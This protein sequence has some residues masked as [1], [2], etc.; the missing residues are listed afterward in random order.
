MI[1]LSKVAQRVY[2]VSRYLERVENT[3][4][5][6]NIHTALLMDM[7]RE[8]EVGW[9][10]LL[11]VFDLG[12]AFMNY[13]P[14]RNEFNVMDFLIASEDN[15]AS[16]VN[17]LFQARENVRTTLDVLP[18]QT[19][20]QINLAHLVVGDTLEVL[21]NR[22]DRQAMLE[23]VLSSCQG[24]RGALDSHMSR[25]MVYDFVQIGKHIERADMTSRILEI[26]SLLMSDARS[27]LMQKYDEILWSNILGAINAQQMFLREM[28]PPVSA[29]K[30]LRFLIHDPRFPRSIHYSLEAMRNY[31]GY[32][33]RPGEVL[34][35]HEEIS[36]MVS[37][38]RKSPVPPGIIHEY[39]DGLQARLGIMHHQMVEH[40]FAP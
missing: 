22:H 5:L 30:V 37:E 27:E 2:W 6:I 36:S 31:I 12:D 32:L 10:T 13:Y 20:Q 38:W 28:Q 21:R 7:P 4:R 14:E 8:L 1:L 23:A 33:P 19:W 29:Q 26:A 18:E 9:S 15:P 3:A 17:S 11:D 24:V 34:S 35:T 40:W 16:L 25:D 39:M